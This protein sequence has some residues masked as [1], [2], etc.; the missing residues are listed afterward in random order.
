MADYPK[1]PNNATAEQLN[2]WANVLTDKLGSDAVSNRN[3]V[4]LD[5]DESISIN[6]RIQLNANFT[7]PD[8]TGAFQKGQIRFNTSTN[9]FQG[10]DGTAW[11][12]FH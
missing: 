9:K 10:Y 4:K 6:G 2:R 8:T 5:V 11:R 7:N 3:N 12:D 1:Y